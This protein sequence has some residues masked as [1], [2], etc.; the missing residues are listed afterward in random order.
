MCCRYR[1]DRE[2]LQRI[3]AQ[4]DAERAPGVDLPPTRY[5]L[6]PGAP[7]PVIRRTRR[8]D[9]LEL[10]LL[11]WGLIPTWAQDRAAFGPKLA[12]A[13]AETLSE[14]PAFRDLVRPR[15]ALIPASGFYEWQR[16]GG[17]T[18]LPHH[19]ARRDGQPFCFA[20]LWTLWRDPTDPDP[21][22]PTLESCT[23]I[24]T[25]P[26]AL[27]RPIHDRMPVM[28]DLD[29]ARAWLDPHH[30][31]PLALLRPSPADAMVATPLDARVNS[32]AHDD[33]ACLTP[34][35]PPPQLDLGL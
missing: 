15:R 25:T 26:N 32:V 13:R 2:H 6:A 22:A 12:N 18:R 30:P 31:D 17:R 14:K 10:A 29:E 4:L 35:A 24:T 11:F 3:L 19:F 8:A 27:L 1:L 7:I 21:A 28:L 9:A 34:A 23:L 5:N 33:P 16:L 20:A